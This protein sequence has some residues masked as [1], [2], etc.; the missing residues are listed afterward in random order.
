MNDR[1]REILEHIISHQDVFKR[2]IEAQ[3]EEIRTIHVETN[4]TITEQHR[5]TRVEII[6]A[7]TISEQR[8]EVEQQATRQEIAQLKQALDL[9]SEQIKQKDVELQEFLTAFRQ[10]TSPKKKKA[11]RERS[12]AVSATLLALEV[13]YRSL[14]VS[15]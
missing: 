14:L 10:T 13:I 12:N 4:K 9:L 1:S 5:A 2:E 3:T 11:L 8:S 7:I 6:E 15:L